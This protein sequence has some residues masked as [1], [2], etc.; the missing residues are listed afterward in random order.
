MILPG[1][2]FPMSTPAH[3]AAADTPLGPRYQGYMAARAS[4]RSELKH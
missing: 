2:P 1:N 3:S 4:A